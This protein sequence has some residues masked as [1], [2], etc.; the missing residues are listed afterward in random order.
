[1]GSSFAGIN[2]EEVRVK[3]N[4]DGS[5]PTGG[6]NGA[7]TTI[8]GSVNSLAKSLATTISNGQSLS[9]EIN[10]EG[11]RLAGLF[12]PASWTTANITFQSSNVSGGTFQNVFD[13]AGNELTLTASGNC[14]ITDIPE[15]APLQYIKIRSGTSATPVNQGADRTINLLLKG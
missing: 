11:F 9:P 2:G 7:P 6:V 14:V 5:I 15:I 13:S 12:M 10:L 3:I 1:M 8:S 4:P